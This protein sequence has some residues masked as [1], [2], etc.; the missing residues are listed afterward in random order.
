MSNI[1]NYT[2]NN[3]KLTLSNRYYW[4]FYLKNSQPNYAPYTGTTSGTCFVV[5]FDFNNPAIFSSGATS[6]DTIYSTQTWSGAA[7]SGVTATTI[8][9]TGIDNGLITFDKLS[10]DTTNQALLSALTA[11]TLYIPSGETRFTM[12]RV[13]G[14][15]EQYEY[16]MNFVTSTGTTGNYMDFCGGFYQ[17]YYKLDGFDYQVLPNR[18]NKGWVSE[19]WLKKSDD[20]CSG[21]TAT[22]IN[23]LYPNNKGFFF[24]MGT[25]AENKFWDIFDGVNTG[26]TSACTTPI[27]CTGT[28]TT[29]CT[30]P[31]ESQIVLSSGVSL[32][33]PETKEIKI[34]NQFMIY[35]RGE[36]TSTH[37]G[38]SY[39]EG[40]EAPEF[41][42]DSITITAVTQ[43][44]TDTRNPFLIYCNKCDSTGCAGG[45]SCADSDCQTV[46]DYS[47]RT[48]PSVSL[49]YNLGVIDNAIGFRVKDDGSI[50][51]RLLSV[52]GA[53][54]GDTYT[55]GVTVTEAYSASG[56]VTT[57]VWDNV[58]IRF[59]AYE[60]MTDA[61]LLC[62]GRRL[63]RLSIYVNG[64][65]KLW[66]DDFLEIVPRRLD[67]NYQKQV[68]VPYN[69]SLG[70]GSQGLLES[71]TFD[72]Q[73]P[74]D[75]GLNIEKNFAG[76]FIGSISQFK[77]YACNLHWVDISN[78]YNQEK[79]RYGL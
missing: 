58:A 46:C 35:H 64:K 73:D 55:S 65:L 33:P 25:R 71:M 67:T 6:A 23:D 37:Y 69:I 54:S 42:G 61:E 9:L 4:D 59:Y 68:A 66:V 28:V 74:D 3:L 76:T 52:T 44:L 10:A 18:F 13:T 48:S 22:T 16:P 32:D 72:G 39:P 77:F 11:S 43:S 5:D 1:I 47:G 56:V 57:N 34:T 17:G 50:G 41:T 20:T 51:Y 26:C 40:E 63:G 38:V 27:G 24:Y 19:F 49:D 79:A 21:T 29:F 70:G 30:V 60:R 12:T 2:P 31:K 78:N 53:C 7:N 15:T 75:L 14:M 62:K 8:G 36:A 45:D